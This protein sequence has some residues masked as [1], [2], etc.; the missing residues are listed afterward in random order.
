[1]NYSDVETEQD[2]RLGS[3]GEATHLP[4]P[5]RPAQRRREPSSGFNVERVNL[6]PR[7]KGRTPSA[8]TRG[9]EYRGGAQ[10]RSD[11]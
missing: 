2:D 8:D 10:G 5:W 1:M 6:S 11:S 4:T 9:G 3:N 7:C